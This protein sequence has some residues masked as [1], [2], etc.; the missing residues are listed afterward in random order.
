ML[1]AGIDVRYPFLLTT[2]YSSHIIEP[3]AQ[4][5]LRPDEEYAGGLPNEDA[6]SFVFDATT[7]FD[8]DKF[9]GYDRIEGGTRANLGF[10]YTGAL[11]NGY[12]LRAI[13]GQSFHLGGLNSF[14]TD[15]L[16]KAGSD[17]GLETDRSDYV[18]MVGI[19]APSGITTS[20]SGRFD[21]SN[22]DLRRADAT[23]GYQGIFWQTALT[24]TSIQAQPLY[25]STS[26]QDEIQTAAAY[27]F[28]DYWSV[29]GSVTYDLNSNVVTRNG[30]GITYDDR[31]T[32]FSLVYKE[33][34]DTD[35]TVANDWSIGA[36]ISFR[37]LGDINVGDADFDDLN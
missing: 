4:L 14:A 2:D 20:L 25:G 7:L 37:T 15:D 36:R 3:I 11:G 27:K 13:A 28:Q 30:I 26:D 12:A 1:T 29:F 21:E 31:D 32:I 10:R 8:R 33:E 22:L 35:Q 17:S 23:I 6:Q 19:D 9:S 5:Y 16:V 24:Y 34:R 18:A